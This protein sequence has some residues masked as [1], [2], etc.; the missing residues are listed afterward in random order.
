MSDLL[1]NILGFARDGQIIDFSPPERRVCGNVEWHP[2]PAKSTT[3]PVPSCCLPVVLW[4][5]PLPIGRSPTTW[6]AQRLEKACRRTHARQP[7]LGNN[8]LSTA[9][10][11]TTVGKSERVPPLAKSQWVKAASPDADLVKSDGSTLLLERAKV[12]S[13][14]WPMVKVTGCWLGESFYCRAREQ[15][16]VSTQIWKADPT[17][18]ARAVWMWR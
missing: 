10:V 13:M 2:Q 14:D 1:D 17:S 9:I 11:G 6:T 15:V 7:P 16:C 12:R 5:P 8:R 18:H 3:W 4:P